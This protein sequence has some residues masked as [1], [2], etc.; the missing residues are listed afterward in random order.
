MDNNDR[1]DWAAV[2]AEDCC[3]SGSHLMEEGQRNALMTS[4]AERL[5]DAYARGYVEAQTS[6]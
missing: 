4:I 6:E 1:K 2:E 5:R 3:R